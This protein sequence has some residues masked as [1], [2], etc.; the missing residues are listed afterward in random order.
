MIAC[1]TSVGNGLMREPV[2][3]VT[4]AID[5]IGQHTD[6]FRLQAASSRRRDVSRAGQAA[7]VSSMRPSARVSAA[8]QFAS[9]WV[10][11]ISDMIASA[12]VIGIAAR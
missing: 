12:F 1:G 4:V 6:E 11:T 10:P 2:N 3:T 9:I 5:G 7:S 8:K